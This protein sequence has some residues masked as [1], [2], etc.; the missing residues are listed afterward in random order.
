MDGSS[1]PNALVEAVA[2]GRSYRIGNDSFLGLAPA[3]CRVL[4][5]D[6]IALVGPSGSG[7]STLL[8]LMA[9]LDRPSSGRIAWPLLG[10]IGD[11]RPTKVACVFQMPSL[12]PALTVVENVELPLLLGRSAGDCRRA[13][14]TALDLLGLG[15]LSKK[16]PEELSGGQAQRVAVARAIAGEPRLLLADEPTSQLDQASA[17]QLL[18]AMLAQFAGKATAIVIATHDIGVAARMDRLWRM[19]HGLL[20]LSAADAVAS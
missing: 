14:L 20:E 18:D 7:K 5:G 1:M 13:A 4:P 10:A 16:L 19:H 15:E 6:R 9:G 2:V 12:L 8:N 11:L 3:T 17:D